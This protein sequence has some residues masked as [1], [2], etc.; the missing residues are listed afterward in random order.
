MITRPR[1]DWKALLP[2]AAEIVRGYD[3]GVLLRQ[4]FYRLVADHSLP[5]T[6]SAYKGLSK[7]TAEAVP[8]PKYF[9]AKRREGAA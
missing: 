6:K 7:Y 8:N 9:A 3:T 4:L 5:N 1:T 2:R